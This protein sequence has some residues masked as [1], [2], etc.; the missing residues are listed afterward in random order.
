MIESRSF[1]LMSTTGRRWGARVALAGVVFSIAVAPA[2]AQISPPGGPPAVRVATVTNQAIAAERQFT[3]RIEAIQSVD[4][5]AR[6]EGYLESVD[7]EGG[8][9]VQK[10]DAL[11][12]IE[13]APYQASLAQAKAQ[14]AASQAAVA[15][16]EADLKNKQ[17]ELDRQGTLADRNVVSEANRDTAEAARDMAQA[18]VQSANADVEQAQAQIETAQL[19]LSYTSITAPIDGRL[20][21]PLVTVGNVVSPN[22]GTMATLVQLDPIRVAF[23]VPSAIYT[24]LLEHVVGS[25]KPTR[26]HFQPTVVL[27]NGRLYDKTGRIAFASNEVDPSTGTVTV[28]ADFDNPNALLLPGQFV[29]VNVTR[30]DEPKLPTIPATALLQDR[31]GPYVFVVKSDDTV[32]QR[33]V[34]IARRDATDISI[35][36][37]LSEGEVVVTGGVQK[38]SAGLK[39]NPITTPPPGAASGQSVSSAAG[40]AT[41]PAPA[42]GSANATTAGSTTAPAAGSSNASSAQN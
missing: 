21:K 40:S 25:G 31:Q 28:Y 29:V 10:G 11:L 20:S 35:S 26:E 27:P 30:V 18:N 5:V 34:D 3:G 1:Q 41:A 38:V 19:N 37:G 8:N 14:L 16:S 24:T 42:S 7:F 36:K 15:G 23:A 33:R 4:L 9:D 32:E 22:T 39:V 17:L 6:V 12:Q 13:Q 2:G